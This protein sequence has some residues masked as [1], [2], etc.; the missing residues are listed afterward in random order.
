MS[1]PDAILQSRKKLDTST[2][3][4]MDE[5]T[6]EGGCGVVGV[7]SSEPIAGRHLLQALDQMKNRVKGKGGGIAAVGLQPD[8]PTPYLQAWI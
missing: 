4:M 5:S 8:Q 1:S 3:V 6:A 2:A 7:A